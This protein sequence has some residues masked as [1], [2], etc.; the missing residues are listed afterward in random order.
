M[1][2][3]FKI[4][5]VEIVDGILIG[6]IHPSHHPKCLMQALSVRDCEQNSMSDERESLIFPEA[7]TACRFID[8]P[9]F[10]LEKKLA[11]EHY[12]YFFAIQFFQD[13]EEGRR[14]NE[15]AKSRSAKGTSKQNNR[16][17]RQV[18]KSP[19]RKRPQ[20]VPERSLGMTLRKRR[21]RTLT[22]PGIYD[23]EIM[24]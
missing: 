23:S 17:S 11:V 16:K 14:G 10:F 19:V 3:F 2:N 4:A 15:S 13:V 8:F 6:E 24:S 1:E 18:T 12:S 7:T 5:I 22:S 21:V 20:A 9:I